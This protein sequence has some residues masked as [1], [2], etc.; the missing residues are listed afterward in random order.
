MGCV[1]G[2]VSSFVIVAGAGAPFKVF[3]LRLR[4]PG[5]FAESLFDVMVDGES[6]KLEW[7]IQLGGKFREFKYDDSDGSGYLKGAPVPK[8]LYS[9]LC[10][11]VNAML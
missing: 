3:R 2:L 1:V 9:S 11:D 7:N 8:I 6:A 5:A 10:Q 4:C